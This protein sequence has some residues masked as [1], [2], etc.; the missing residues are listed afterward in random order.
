ML[1]T[2]HKGRAITHD[3]NKVNE[4]GRIILLELSTTIN[5]P[6]KNDYTCININKINYIFIDL[7]GHFLSHIQM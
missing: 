7:F 5:L 3:H 4:F 2:T 6:I 1:N